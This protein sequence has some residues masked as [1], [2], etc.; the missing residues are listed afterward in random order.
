MLLFHDL[1]IQN[2]VVHIAYRSIEI[3]IID[4][5]TVMNM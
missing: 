4:V 3:P 1:P 5:K 2:K